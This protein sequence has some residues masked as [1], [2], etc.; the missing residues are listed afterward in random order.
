MRS[1]IEYAEHKL[2][3]TEANGIKRRRSR[4]INQDLLEIFEHYDSY[5]DMSQYADDILDVFA[6]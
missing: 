1:E 4:Q 3:H 5:T 6:Q 2:A